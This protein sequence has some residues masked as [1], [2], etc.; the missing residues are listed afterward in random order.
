MKARP[1]NSLLQNWQLRLKV[2]ELRGERGHALRA[3]DD[4]SATGEGGGEVYVRAEKADGPDRADLLAARRAPDRAL[5]RVFRVGELF[6]FGVNVRVEDA[7]IVGIGV[8]HS[9]RPVYRA[10]GHRSTRVRAHSVRLRPAL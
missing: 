1:T 5:Q 6:G 9:L 10:G 3:D 2:R 7:G 8:S 4:A